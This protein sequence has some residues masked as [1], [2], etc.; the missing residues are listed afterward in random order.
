MRDALLAQSRPMLYSL[1][2]WGEAGVQ[3]WGNQTGSSWRMSGDIEPNWPKIL[4]ILNQNTFYLHNTNFWGHSDADMLEIGNEGVSLQEA[5][6]HFALWAAMKSPL[7]IGTDLA[8]VSQEIVEVLKNP[9]LLAFNQDNV[10]GKPAMPYKWGTN[11]DW[12]FNESFPAEYWAG[13]SKA[14]TLVLMFNPYNTTERK[15][16]IWEEI[17][18]LD[19][20][21]TYVVTD[22]WTGEDLQCWKEGIN[23][24]V[25]AHDTTALL[26]GPSCDTVEDDYGVAD[27]EQTVRG[28]T[29]SR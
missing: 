9:Y 2:Q 8:K 19:A 4:S 5:R 6:T 23:R 1:C 7:L 25:L 10:F 11:P 12:T 16:A 24:D 21:G 13:Q 15:D 29:E 3:Q 18:G 28:K 26:V 27:P 14:G 22:V 17:P 20:N